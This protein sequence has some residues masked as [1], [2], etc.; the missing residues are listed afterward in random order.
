MRTYEAVL[1]IDDA[2]GQEDIEKL[3]AEYKALAEKHG[4]ASVEVTPW[5]RK[6]LAYEI[7]DKQYAHYVL[8]R[9]RA[10]H[11]VPRELEQVFRIEKNM[12]RFQIFLVPEGTPDLPTY[13]EVE[14]LAELITDRGKL[15]PGRTTRYNPVQ[16]REVSRQVKR[17]RLLALLPYTTISG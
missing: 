5:G 14:K 17:A 13:R 16:Q 6:K 7:N 15:R 8:F 11:N 12:L 9:I 3:T 10:T 2:L 1:V 4:A